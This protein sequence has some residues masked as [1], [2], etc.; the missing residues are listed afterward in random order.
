LN[1]FEQPYLLISFFPG[2][3][4]FLLAKW[5]HSENVAQGVNTLKSSKALLKFNDTNHDLVPAYADIV[6]RYT[7]EKEKILYTEFNQLM[8]L[9]NLDID[10]LKD[11]LSTSTYIPRHTSAIPYIIM[12]HIGS[13]ISLSN[14]KKVFPN[15]K[16]LTVTCKDRLQFD[17]AY[18]CKY[19]DLVYVENDWNKH[20]ADFVNSIDADILVPLDDVISLNLNHLK[21][22][23]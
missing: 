18:L 16:T 9:P 10:V 3:R 12:T 14:W 23:L 5:L 8:S 7:S 19:G 20:G 22:I 6:L 1:I 4:G 13:T 11:L 15:I 21:G 17:D 2:T